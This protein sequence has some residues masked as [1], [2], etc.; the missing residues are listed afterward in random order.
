MRLETE[1]RYDLVSTAKG[2]STI[3]LATVGTSVWKIKSRRNKKRQKDKMY[4]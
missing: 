3:L 2:V 1:G 4:N